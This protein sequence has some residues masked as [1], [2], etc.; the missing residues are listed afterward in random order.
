MVQGPC[1]HLQLHETSTVVLDRLNFIIDRL[2]VISTGSVVYVKIV[3]KVCFQGNHLAAIFKVRSG[4][5]W[6][7]DLLDH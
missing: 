6:P 5:L 7:T 3:A 4:L 1:A 2:N